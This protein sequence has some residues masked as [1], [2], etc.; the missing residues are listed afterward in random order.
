MKNLFLPLVLASFASAQFTS[1]GT[2]CNTWGYTCANNRHPTPGVLVAAGSTSIG[3][4]YT[5]EARNQI[6]GCGT[7]PSFSI[8]LTGAQQCSLPFGFQ[9]Q[10]S[11]IPFYFHLGT[12][13]LLSI[14]D[15]RDLIGLILYHQSYIQF[16]DGFFQPNWI[17]TTNGIVVKINE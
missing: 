3:K 15:N 4:S 13:Q 6:S 7:G 10:L 12:Y 11:V 2:S 9:C 1:I 16:A 17:F 5:L 14:P 8:I